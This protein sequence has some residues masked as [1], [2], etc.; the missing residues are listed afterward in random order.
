MQLEYIHFQSCK[1][2]FVVQNIRK[3][4]RDLAFPVTLAFL[5]NFKFIKPLLTENNLNQLHVYTHIFGT[6]HL[7]TP[8]AVKMQNQVWMFQ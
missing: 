1:L 5:E 2:L 7:P 3:S 8:T 6:C 4:S